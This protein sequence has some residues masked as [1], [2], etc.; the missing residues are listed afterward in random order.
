MY[1]VFGGENGSGVSKCTGF[2][3]GE[4]PDNAS[5]GDSIFFEIQPLFYLT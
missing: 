5:Y 4:N 2:G 3:V 1:I